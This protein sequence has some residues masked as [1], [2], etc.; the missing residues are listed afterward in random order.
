MAATT[1]TPRRSFATCRPSQ[2]GSNGHQE[3][4][5]STIRMPFHGSCS[6]CHHFHTNHPFTFSLDSTVHTRLPCERCNH[7]MFGLG[8]VSTQSTLASV[9]SGF[10]FTPRAC[11]DRPG[12][13]Q[14]QSASQAETVPGTSTLG[15]L[16]TITERRSPA[17]SRSTSDI[18]T[19]TRTLSET[20]LSGQEVGGSI[21]RG[22]LDGG[23]AGRENTL[24][25]SPENQALHPQTTTLRRLRTIGHRFKKRF[26]AT[27]KDWKLPRVRL[28]ITYAPSVG[29]TG[30]SSASASTT[31]VSSRQEQS[32]NAEQLVS[33]TGDDTEDRHASLRARRRELTLA[34]ERE[35]AS[36]RKCEC[37]PE[38]ACI[39]GSNV[40]QVDRADTPDIFVPTYVFPPNHSSTGSSNSQPSQNSAHG[41]D[42]L[43]HIGGH[44]ESSRRSSSADESSSAADSGSRRIRLS[45]GSTLWSNG[46][47]LSLRT[48]RPLASR[49]SS[50]PVG[51]RAQHLAGVRTGLQATSFS[52]GSSWP[53]TARAQASLDDGS[54]PGGS[55][56]PG[57]SRNRDPS[58]HQCSASLA[59]L[60]NHQEEEELVNGVSPRS[61]TPMRDVDEVTPTPRSGIR[62]EENSHGA[63]P[64]GSEGLSSALQNLTNGDMTD[65]E[66]QSP[67]S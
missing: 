39:S 37:G 4:S 61:H 27:R 33:G 63:L 32:E 8:R 25:E 40:T 16:T 12:Q 22:E 43:I 24:E 28:Q 54:V 30:H 1:G 45:Q 44:L 56:H 55:N 38:C 23:R 26:S 64:V 66:V 42:P 47:S 34:K 29:M 7:P 20:S 50:M 52:P 18:R 59:S 36:V 35:L 31:G 5:E 60:P 15:L 58:S 17:A 53:E 19:P 21:G 6:R 9:E 3:S 62:M 11:V 41:L 46:S 65:H 10:T 2:E 51:T 13:Q 67:E 57:S 49:A 48:R 14:Q